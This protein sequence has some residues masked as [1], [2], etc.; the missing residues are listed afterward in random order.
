MVDGLTDST[1]TSFS[2]LLEIVKNREARRATVLGVA[3]SRTRLSDLDDNNKKTD[4]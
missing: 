1:D 3:K 2:K 4:G